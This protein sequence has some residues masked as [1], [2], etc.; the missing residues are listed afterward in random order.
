MRSVSREVPW[1]RPR[2]WA[3]VLCASCAMLCAGVGC[4]GPTT[5]HATGARVA[6]GELTVR[7]VRF[8]GRAGVFRIHNATRQTVRRV[9]VGL[10]GVGCAGP[11]KTRTTVQVFDIRLRAGRGQS[12]AFKFEHR[13]DK[14]HVAIATDGEK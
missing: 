5:G 1:F 3:V 12:F 7:L 6:S 4:P 13:C 2:L 8:D 9:A 10:R 11:R 14:A